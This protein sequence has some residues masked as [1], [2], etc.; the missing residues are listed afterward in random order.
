MTS[1]QG[2]E[3]SSALFKTVGEEEV[4]GGE[5]R[6]TQLLQPEA[7]SHLVS[8]WLAVSLFGSNLF[9]MDGQFLKVLNFISRY[10]I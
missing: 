7:Q 9:I 6:S 1:L 8:I 3:H 5:D 2:E 4:G 10:I